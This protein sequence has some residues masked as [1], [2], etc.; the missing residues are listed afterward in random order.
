MRFLVL[1]REKSGERTRRINYTQ[2]G[3][4]VLLASVEG[5]G[6]VALCTFS[7]YRIPAATRHALS[8]AVNTTK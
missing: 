4:T 8:I 6:A 2:I 7:R 3:G 1:K 5:F